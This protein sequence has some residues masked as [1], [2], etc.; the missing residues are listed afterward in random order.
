[1]T[2][3]IVL[4]KECVP[5]RVKT[6][7]T[8]PFSPEEAAALASAS[9]ADTLEAVGRVA[10][11]RHLLWFD[12]AA[13]RG[14]GFEVVQQPSGGLD[15]RIAAAFE[16][17]DD[18]AVLVGMDTPQL[19]PAVLQAVLDDDGAD[20]WFG[21]AT[22]GGWWALGLEPGRR[23]GDLVRGTPMST[24][25]TGASQ[26]LRL[27]A[28]ALRVRRLPTLTDVDHVAE[29]FAVAEAAPASRFATVLGV[30]APLVDAV[31]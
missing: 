29:A 28:A 26:L 10:A 4:A 21:P 24:D 17:T 20:A 25:V 27:S 16:W 19:D 12:G 5:G 22:D 1:M 15:E 18:R 8:P 23:R 30:L 3:V 14:T 6:R 13:P 9:L 7:L 2:T 11:D 31:A